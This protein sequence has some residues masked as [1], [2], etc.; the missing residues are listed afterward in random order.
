MSSVERARPVSPETWHTWLYA[1]GNGTLLTRHQVL[2]AMV[3]SADATISP[4]KGKRS[5]AH[6]NQSLEL[7]RAQRTLLQVVKCQWPQHMYPAAI[8][9]LAALTQVFVKEVCSLQRGFR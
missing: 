7:E 6:E 1:G 4:A 3:V 5:S 2:S 9:S 8:L